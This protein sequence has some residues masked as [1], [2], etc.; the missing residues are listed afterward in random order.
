MSLSDL[1]DAKRLD[2]RHRS[3]R[4]ERVFCDKEPRS[5]DEILGA[6]FALMGKRKS[7]RS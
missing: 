1:K 6:K 7:S 4:A 3:M 5:I 2:L